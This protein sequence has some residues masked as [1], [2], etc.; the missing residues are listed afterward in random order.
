MERSRFVITLLLAAALS[1]AAAAQTAPDESAGGLDWT[2]RAA[3]RVFTSDD[4]HFGEVH[5]PVIAAN[6][7]AGATYGVL[8][9]WLVHDD[10]HEIVQMFAPMFTYNQTYG[11]G[12]SG[13]YYYYPSGDAKLR[14]LLEKTQ[15]SNYRASFQYVDRSLLDDRAT[16]L[17]DTNYEADGDAQ[18]Y[19]VGPA[20]TKGAEASERLLERLARAEA[21]V[22]FWGAFVAA[23]GWQFRRTAVQPGPFYSPA[24]IPSDLRT[25]TIYSLP[26]AT[27]SRDTRDLAF[28]PAS[29]SL[30]ELFA[31]YS[32]RELGGSADYEHYGG[33]WRYYTPTGEGLVAAFHAQT[34]WSGGGNVP[35]TALSEL[36]GARSLRGFAEGRFQDR[37]SAF[38]NFEERWRVHSID[39]VH[40]LTEFQ[41]APFLDAGT[42]FPS[43]GE[44]RS[45]R[46][47]TVAG[48]A[49]RAVVKPAVV[50]KVEFG[51]GREGPAVFVGIDYPF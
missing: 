41:V 5:L 38:V 16:L 36:G 40:S 28:T 45:R 13:T 51:V 4:K 33:Q 43:P 32:G 21:G 25:S 3:A 27:L 11:A 46:V 14:V 50:G 26:R 30:A 18:F 2:L 12:F 34:E 22:K 47:E 37:G 42:V 31:E 39:L 7:N 8:P 20:S 17:V 6:P 19:G 24:V 48:L 29:G 23:A 10:R 44:A 1:G 15:V 35:F 9:V 49:L